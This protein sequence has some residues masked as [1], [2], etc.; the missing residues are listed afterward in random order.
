MPSKYGC[1]NFPTSETI[2]CKH[3][4]ETNSYEQPRKQESD[5]VYKKT[6]IKIDE[7]EI[8]LSY[9]NSGKEDKW[10]LE[11]LE[12]LYGKSLQDAADCLGVSRSTMKRIW[13]KHGVSRWPSSKRKKTGRVSHKQTHKIELHQG[14]EG[15]ISCISPN[16]YPN[17]S[18]VVSTTSCS[19]TEQSIQHELEL[20]LKQTQLNLLYPHSAHDSLHS[21]RGHPET[22]PGEIVT[23]NTSFPM[24]SLQIQS[25]DKQIFECSRELPSIRVPHLEKIVRN[26]TIGVPVPKLS[27][28]AATH[29]E[30]TASIKVKARYGENIIKFVLHY[31]S[32]LV[33][34]EKEVQKRLNLKLGTF[35]LEYLDVD[36]DWI[37]IACDEDLQ[38]ILDVFLSKGIIRMLVGDINGCQAKINK[39]KI[40]K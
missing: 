29:G 11:V 5:L 32:A 25:A 38:Q 15:T 24:R 8:C 13:R 28:D 16:L 4:R 22:H 37:L 17:I 39:C 26:D 7:S 34:L 20:Q 36:G 19:T 3:V 23:K 30:G 31:P 35:T 18:S 1:K 33:D 6:K 12:Q 14:A 27:M 40:C 9:T 2:S 21:A 10:S